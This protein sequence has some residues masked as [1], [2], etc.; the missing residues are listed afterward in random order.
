M[1][2]LKCPEGVLRVEGLDSGNC[3]SA[4][5]SIEMDHSAFLAQGANTVD[6]SIQVEQTD[7]SCYVMGFRCPSWGPQSTDVIEGELTLETN[8]AQ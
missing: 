6:I 7:R 1:L 3:P 4:P 5:T 2:T 8:E